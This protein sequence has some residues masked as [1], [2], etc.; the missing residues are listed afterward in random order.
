MDDR[1]TAKLEDSSRCG[2]GKKKP[3]AKD[4]DI[5]G[6]GRF[7]SIDILLLIQ[8]IFQPGTVLGLGHC[9]VPQVQK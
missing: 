2:K 6:R 9:H 8:S 7:S 1:A 5:T 3:E 4:K